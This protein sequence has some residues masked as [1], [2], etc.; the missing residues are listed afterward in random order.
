METKPRSPQSL[1]AEWRDKAAELERLGQPGALIFQELAAQLER[2][3]QDWEAEPLD[4]K[5]ASAVSGFSRDT[6]GRLVKARLVENVGTPRRPRI[7]RRDLPRKIPFKRANTAPPPPD[8][9]AEVEKAG[10]LRLM[11]RK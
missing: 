4:F 11:P 9:V 6:L 3:I 5:A 7:R 8:L 10:G 2:T 1:V